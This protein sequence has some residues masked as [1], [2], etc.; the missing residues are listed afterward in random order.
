MDRKKVGDWFAFFAPRFAALTLVAGFIIRIVLLCMPMTEINFGL[1]QFARLFLLGAVN[2]L[3]FSAIGIIPAFVVYSTMTDGKYGRPAGYIILGILAGLTFYFCCF[4]DI[5]DEYGSVVPTIVNALM[6][7]LLSC[8][9]IKFFFPGVRRGWRNYAIWTTMVAYAMFVIFINVIG[10]PVFWDEFGVRYNFIA[11]DYLVYTNEV[12][13]NIVESY[14]MVPVV[15][16]VLAGASLICWLMTRGHKVGNSGVASFRRWALNLALVAVCSSA[17]AAWLHWSYRNMA[18]NDMFLTQLQENGCWDFLEA[19]ASNELDYRQ[20]YPLQ[21][22]GEAASLKR[23]MLGQDADGVAHMGDSSSVALRKNIVLITIESM[24]AS[25]MEAYG[26]D[27]GIT[28]NLDRIR[29]ASIAFDNLYATGNRTVRGLEAVTLCI[30][31]SSGESIVKRPENSGLFTTGGVLRELGYNTTYIYGGDSYFDNMKAFFGGNGYDVFDKASYDRDA[32]LFSNIW[33]TCDEDS[34]REALS[35]F[36]AKASAG[37]PFFAH[38]MTISNHRPYTYPEGRIEYDG[39]PMS[40]SAAVKYTDWCI[41]DFLAR[42]K[43]KPWFGD[44]VFVIMADHCASSAGKTSLPLEGYHIPAMIYAPGFLEPMAVDKICS[45]IDV[46][47]TLFSLLGFEY[48][49]MFYGRDILSDDFRQRAFMATYQDLGYY[50]DGILTV[51]S[52]VRQTRQ[53]KVTDNGDWTYTETLLQ[54]PDPKTAAEAQALY[55]CANLGL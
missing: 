51:L 31:P 39:N 1:L 9:A 40:R 43:E 6:A 32:M 18:T 53:F 26:S 33:G 49:S 19:F 17:G 4:N 29:R 21:G 22:D 15:L 30:P 7:L 12:I 14:P 2:D 25:F 47:P 34:Y 46:M 37:E 23:E 38:I 35:I 10:E 8:F 41:G 24:S 52:P 16:G 45:Q 42:A 27:R 36:D 28:P 48:D 55:Q 11:V 44:T 13:G 54:D 3:A 50:A 5:T 20:F